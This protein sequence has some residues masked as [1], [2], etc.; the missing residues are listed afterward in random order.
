M[1]SKFAGPL[2]RSLRF[3]DD[4]GFKFE[5]NGYV[6]AA[7]PECV[8]ATKWLYNRSAGLT[9]GADAKMLARKKKKVGCVL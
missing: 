4:V 2:R 6:K 7:R 5:G 8:G 3:D 9:F 1:S